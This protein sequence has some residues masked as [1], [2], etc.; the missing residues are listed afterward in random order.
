LRELKDLE[1]N[2]AKVNNKVQNIVRNRKDYSF[3][4]LTTPGIGPVTVSSIIAEIEDIT[5]FSSGKQ[6]IK[7]SGLDLYGSQGRKTHKMRSLSGSHCLY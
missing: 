4:L 1:E 5:N 2:I 6:L 3:S 7:L